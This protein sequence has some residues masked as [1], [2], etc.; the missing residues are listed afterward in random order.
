[1][2]GRSTGNHRGGSPNKKQQWPS[3]KKRTR[4]SANTPDDPRPQNRACLGELSRP[5]HQ[6]ELN[7]NYS[8]QLPTELQLKIIE[9]LH[10]EDILSIRETCLHFYGILQDPKS[11]RLWDVVREDAGILPADERPP[12]PTL[13]EKPPLPT[14]NEIVPP[15]PTPDKNWLSLPTPDKKRLSLPTLDEKQP[16]SPA[17]NEKEPDE[18][19]PPWPTLDEIRVAKY[20]LQSHCMSCKVRKAYPQWE[21]GF[22]L[23]ETCLEPRLI[24]NQEFT[25]LY[26]KTFNR[27]EQAKEAMGW[28]CPYSI[29][30]VEAHEVFCTSSPRKWAITAAERVK[31]QLILDPKGSYVELGDETASW[32]KATRSFCSETLKSLVVPDRSNQAAFNRLARQRQRWISELILRFVPLKF[33]PEDIPAMDGADGWGRFIYKSVAAGTFEEWNQNQNRLLGIVKDRRNARLAP[34]FE[35]KQPPTACDG[36]SEPQISPSSIVAQLGPFPSEIFLKICSMTD[37][38]TLC[39]LEQVSCSTKDILRSPLAEGVWRR[40]RLRLGLEGKFPGWG[41]RSFVR[42]AINR[43][44]AHCSAEGLPLW[45]FAT[46]LCGNCFSTHVMD[47]RTAPATLPTSLKNSV[48]SIRS[49]LFCRAGWVKGVKR[50]A[51][52]VSKSYLEAIWTWAKSF[53]DDLQKVIPCDELERRICLQNAEFLKIAEDGARWQKDR[54]RRRDHMRRSRENFIKNKLQSRYPSLEFSEVTRRSSRWEAIV[55]EQYPLSELEW[56]RIE[57]EILSIFSVR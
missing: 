2:P 41:E 44:C 50:D 23:C 51:G 13:N 15:L 31:W 27:K 11:V 45:H 28:F 53:P 21:L 25:K 38:K 46:T 48:P 1:M 10:G 19:R 20:V 39:I 54:D 42:Y 16:S 24:S 37:M 22:R 49:A 14:L 9:G 57:K 56:P 18:K 32:L 34:L 52:L 55:D 29:P 6:P 33:V 4:A 40:V 8:F 30:G 47:P 43:T 12:L 36:K 5:K 35:G 7:Q 3:P 26:W 17:L